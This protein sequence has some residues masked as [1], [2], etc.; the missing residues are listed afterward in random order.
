MK[1]VNE[2]EEIHDFLCEIILFLEMN[3]DENKEINKDEENVI[4]HLISIRNTLCWVLE[5][6]SIIN[7]K[8]QTGTEIDRLISMI[9]EDFII[10]GVGIKDFDF[11]KLRNDLQ[12]MN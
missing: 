3:K 11:Y 6:T 8:E 9:I 5:H 12:K 1:S 10:S 2:I 4:E 7:G